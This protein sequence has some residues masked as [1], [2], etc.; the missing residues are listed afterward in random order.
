MKQTTPRAALVANANQSL[1]QVVLLIAVAGAVF[2]AA[3]GRPRLW[4]RDEPRNAGCAVEMMERGDWVVPM[5]NAELRAQKPV[6]LYWFMMTAYATFGVNEF[7]ARFWSATLAVGTVLMT[8]QIGRRLFDAMSGRWGGLVLATCPMF[9]LAARAATPD[10]VLIFFMT[11][12]TLLY[13]QGAFEDGRPTPGLFPTRWGRAAAMYAAMGMATLAKGPIGFVLPTAVIGMF[14]L[15]VRLPAAPG[16]P[17]TTGWRR[18]R[19]LAGR[20]L[21]PFA[22]GHFLRTV[23]SMRPLTAVVAILVV[24]LPWYFWVGLRTEG[25]WLRGFLLDDNVGRFA[26]PLE[27]HGGGPWYYPITILAGTFPWVIVLIPAV[28]SA[29]RWVR[30]DDP[31]GAGYLLLLC[32][33]CVYVCIFTLASTKLPSYVTPMY[34]ALA[35][36]AGSYLHR[37]IRRDPLPDDLRVGLTFGS[38]AVIGLA[39]VVGVAVAGG[40]VLGGSQWLAAFGLIPTIAGVAC[41]TL[42]RRQ[43]RSGAVATLTLAATMLCLAVFAIGASVVDRYQQNHR[44][45]QTIRAN[46]QAPRVASFGRLEPSWVYYLRAPIREIRASGSDAVAFLESGSDAFLI[47]TADRYDRLRPGLLE[48]VKVLETVPYFG[49]KTELVVLGRRAHPSGIA[50]TAINR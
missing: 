14:L 27:G 26:Q 31:A 5:F 38:L 9:V 40:I 16:G 23:W 22:P 30:R 17:V 42:A 25:A 10:S 24:A 49:H 8:W 48:D 11:L 21:R 3:L 33:V 18:W 47:T 41:L 39:I 29:V 20:A 43:L 6:L 37:W 7:A 36:L 15:I 45:L 4:D 1:R 13:V 28:V 46:H 44:L 34:H 2:F 50:P 32:W 19:Q 12:A 35:L